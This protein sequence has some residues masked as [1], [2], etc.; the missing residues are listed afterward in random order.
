[1]ITTQDPHS[2]LLAAAQD[3]AAWCEAVCRAHGLPG[4]STADAWTSP[5]RT[6]PLYPDAVTLTPGGASAAALL[7]AIDT[8]SLGCSVKDSFAALDLGPE[9]FRVLFEAQWI[10]RPAG[11]PAPAGGPP[12]EWSGVSTAGELHRW[13]AAWGDGEPSG[14][15]R[16]ALLT[17]GTVFLA[18]RADPG[19]RIVAGAVVNRTGP[20]VGVSNLFARGDTPVGA[21]WAGTLAAVAAR[22]P[23]LPVVGYESGDDLDAAL[24]AGFTTLGPLRV[25]IAAA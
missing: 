21:A 1:M 3:N 7:A 23:G 24:R 4:V 20:V 19:G 14:L 5:R 16:P 13:E 25:W 17:G 15:F 8:G 12:L 10:H 18:G 22:W 11:P 9:G 2:L 6:P